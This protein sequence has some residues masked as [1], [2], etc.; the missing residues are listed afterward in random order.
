MTVDYVT[1]YL[2]RESKKNEIYFTKIPIDSL[3]INFDEG[4]YTLDSIIV[5]IDNSSKYLYKTTD[6]SLGLTGSLR[7]ERPKQGSKIKVVYK[8]STSIFEY[9][10]KFNMIHI[11]IS[12]CILTVQHTNRATTYE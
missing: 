5:I 1:D 10:S 4:F 6:K 2:K 9:N 8:N 7:F 11:C 12:D 3:Q